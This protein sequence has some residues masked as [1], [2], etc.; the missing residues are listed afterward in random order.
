MG[1]LDGKVSII[2]G[3]TV[4]QGQDS[5]LGR[6]SRWLY[7]PDRP[8]GRTGDRRL[9]D[10]VSELGRVREVDGAVVDVEGDAAP[11]PQRH[12]RDLGG[13]GNRERP[14]SSQP[15]R[16]AIRRWPTATQ[17]DGG[18]AKG[19]PKGGRLGKETGPAHNPCHQTGT[20]TG[21]S[22]QPPIAVWWRQGY[23][24]VPVGSRGH[25]EAVPDRP[26]AHRH[27]HLQLR[28]QTP[29]SVPRPRAGRAIRPPALHG[30]RWRRRPPAR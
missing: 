23:R 17:G 13:V 18:Q 8:G 15:V 2:T 20:P 11:A 7:R 12:P 5:N 3:G 24:V 25:A 29:R 10:A 30:T 6:R 4:W 14:T 16:S 26:V 21:M 28:A 1:L 19:G 27:H 9:G 22:L